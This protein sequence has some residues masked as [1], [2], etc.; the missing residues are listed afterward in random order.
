[1]CRVIML[2]F[3]ARPIWTAPKTVIRPK[4]FRV[5][6]SNWIAFDIGICILSPFQPNRIT[7][8]IPPRRRIVIPEVVVMGAGF[9]I[10]IL[11]RK[12]Q[13][14]RELLPIPIR[15]FL[16]GGMTKRITQRVV[17]PHHS[18][19]VVGHRPWRPQ[20]IRQDVEDALG[21]RRCDTNPHRL[22]VVLS[23]SPVRTAHH[24]CPAPCRMNAS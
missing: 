22:L 10:E 18:V 6:L 8:H 20:V 15:V 4:P 12:A 14:E 5:C 19:L 21:L 23:A 1:M 11:P 24:P 16:R 13:V 7:L 2:C 17:L 9:R 3:P